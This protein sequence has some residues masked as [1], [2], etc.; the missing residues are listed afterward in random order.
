MPIRGSFALGFEGVNVLPGYEFRMI[1]LSSHT[2]KFSEIIP[3]NPS[4][5]RSMGFDDVPG[6]N[7]F[8]VR[9]KV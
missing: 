4:Y 8:A 3:L 9:F 7:L 1:Y 5:L 2:I 6:I